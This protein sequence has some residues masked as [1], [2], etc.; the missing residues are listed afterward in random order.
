[1]SMVFSSIILIYALIRLSLENLPI[2]LDALT[3]LM[4]YSYSEA[5]PVLVAIHMGHLAFTEKKKGYQHLLAYY[6]NRSS[7]NVLQLWPFL[8]PLSILSLS[9][10]YCYK[11]HIKSGF[12]SHLLTSI[13]S[14]QEDPVSLM[15]GWMWISP[16]H[17]TWINK[18]DEH[19][20][21]FQ[22]KSWSNSKDQFTIKDGH[23]KHQKLSTSQPSKTKPSKIKTN[24]NIHLQFKR[25]SWP[26]SNREY[27]TVRNMG[28]FQLVDE[29][30]HSK[31]FPWFEVIHRLNPPLSLIA[32]A[33]IGFYGMTK[34]HTKQGVF[35]ITTTVILYSITYST[36]RNWDKDALLS[37]FPLAPLFIISPFILQLLKRTK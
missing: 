15:G 18:G 35:I 31:S 21:F 23:L 4:L 22:G 30:G 27:T 2:T 25:A 13:Q 12:K 33:I 36:S 8:L 32:F 9:Y 17:A 6:Q 11:S 24:T 1:M 34:Y 14:P 28:I 5:L 10:M 3:S 26:L 37:S 29:F 19:T 7:L 16:F 20:I